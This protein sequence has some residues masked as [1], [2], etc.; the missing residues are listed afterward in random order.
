MFL[1]ESFEELTVVI[2]T[3]KTNKEILYKC[4]A[5]IDNK[6][7]I[8]IV[9]NGNDLSLKNEI[10]NKFKN[11]KVI[12]S[13][14]NLGYGG[15]N[16]LGCKHVK[17]RYVFISN[18]DTI[19]NE[20]FFLN[21]KNYINLNINFNI[22]GASYPSHDEYLPYGGF[23]NKST[24]IYKTKSYDTNDLKDVDWVVGCSMLI[25]LKNLKMNNLFDENIFFFYDET[26]L[27]RRIKKSGGKVLNSKRLVV[28]HLGQ[29]SSIGSMKSKKLEAEK[30]RNWHLMWSEFYY[31]KKHNSFIFAFYKV[32]GKLIRSLI[33]MIF[34][35]ITNNKEK[36]VIYKYR[37]FGLINSILGK[38]SWYRIEK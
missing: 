38:K 36:K 31:H 8:I 20:K 4:I 6:I 23:S 2:V 14:K 35:S 32:I 5:S 7:K 12:L 17:T 3:Y 22:I 26:D 24:E 15:G 13:E 19:Y 16:N 25:D 30:F 29:K 18:P 27:C 33:K 1:D 21:V 11:I 10:E 34:F 37:F 28:N 9:E